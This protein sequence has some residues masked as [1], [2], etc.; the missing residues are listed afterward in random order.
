MGP[1]PLDTLGVWEYWK[2]DPDSGTEMMREKMENGHEIFDQGDLAVKEYGHLAPPGYFIA[3]RRLR[4]MGWRVKFLDD[5]GEVT[6]KLGRMLEHNVEVFDGE[7]CP[8]A[9]EMYGHLIPE[10]GNCLS[11]QMNGSRGMRK[12][13]RV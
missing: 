8:E 2:L 3:V 1:Q 4:F 9:K 12:M 11:P 10:F 6:T 5:A 13:L 7:D